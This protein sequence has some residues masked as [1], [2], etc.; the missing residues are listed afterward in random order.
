MVRTFRAWQAESKKAVADPMV[1]R[2]IEL[3]SRVAEGDEVFVINVHAM[4]CGIGDKVLRIDGTPQP[5]ASGP[6]P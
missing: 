4:L 5:G 1:Q 2:L 3:Q 6:A